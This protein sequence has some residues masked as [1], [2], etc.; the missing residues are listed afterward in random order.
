M[1][2]SRNNIETANVIIAKQAEYIDAWFEG[3]SHMP[4]GVVISTNNGGLI[5]LDHSFGAMAGDQVL[6]I[7]F[8]DSGGDTLQRLFSMT[9]E[10]AIAKSG[11]KSPLG[12]FIITYGIGSDRNTWSAPAYYD[13]VTVEYDILADG[14][15]VTTVKFRATGQRSVSELSLIHI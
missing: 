7:K 15:E 6:T 4:S 12:Y 8:A 14:L 3:D 11:I 9:I 5:N 13:F 10:K 1:T 2:F